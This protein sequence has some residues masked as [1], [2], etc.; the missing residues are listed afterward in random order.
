[1]LSHYTIISLYTILLR[2]T[3]GC[4]MFATFTSTAPSPTYETF[5]LS[6]LST[7]SFNLY[8]PIL[9]PDALDLSDLHCFNKC[10]C[11]PTVSESLPIC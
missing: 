4:V 11:T 9:S 2:S 6:I 8:S 10:I 7:F 5:S 1:M 3:R